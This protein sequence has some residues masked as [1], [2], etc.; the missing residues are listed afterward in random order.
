MLHQI[1]TRGGGSSDPGE[2]A[3]PPP[4]HAVLFEAGGTFTAAIHSM[5][6]T[7]PTRLTHRTEPRTKIKALRGGP[8]PAPRKIEIN[9]YSTVF[10]HGSAPA[11][12]HRAPTG[13]WHIARVGP[14][15]VPHPPAQAPPRAAPGRRTPE[16]LAPGTSPGGRWPKGFGS[17]AEAL[18]GRNLTH[19][20][21]TPGGGGQDG[22]RQPQP[23]PTSL[24]SHPHQRTHLPYNC[25]LPVQWGET[26]VS[27]EGG[28]DHLDLSPW[29]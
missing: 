14:A 17:K 7:K 26:L 24:P 3:Q 6:R 2:G 4:A 1:H 13:R 25:P 5:Y 23:E 9:C 15:H 21:F 8:H 16:V 28:G 20:C 18:G 19:Y 29:M 12:P 11:P 27:C 22:T 10:R